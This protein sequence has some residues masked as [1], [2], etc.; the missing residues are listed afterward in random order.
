MDERVPGAI[1]WLIILGVPLIAF[2]SIRW[3]DQRWPF[4]RWVWWQYAWAAFAIW[5]AL[6]FVIQF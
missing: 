5:C 2:L 1:A 3:G 4:K 6:H